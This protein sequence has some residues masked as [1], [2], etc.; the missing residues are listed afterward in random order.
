MEGLIM[1][2]VFQSQER[3][4]TVDQSE[5]NIAVW[6]KN[7]EPTLLDIASL[8]WNDICSF[9]YTQL[10]PMLRQSPIISIVVGDSEHSKV[11]IQRLFSII[12][13]L[14]CSNRVY[15]YADHDLKDFLITQQNQYKIP[16]LVRLGDT[17]PADWIV[18]NKGQ[19][20]FLIFGQTDKKRSFGMF[21]EQDIAVSLF[22][23]FYILFWFHST[24]EAFG[25]QTGVLN[26]GVPLAPPFQ[27]PTDQNIH[28]LR[29]GKL[30]MMGTFNT[31]QHA[32]IV[33]ASQLSA[34]LQGTFLVVPPSLHWGTPQQELVQ[35]DIPRQLSQANSTLL[36]FPHELPQINISTQRLLLDL[37]GKKISLRLE[38][39]RSKAIQYRHAL[40]GVCLNPEWK[41]YPQR[42][43]NQ[44][45]G[46]V[47]ISGSKQAHKVKQKE[48]IVLRPVEVPISLPYRSPERNLP[49][50]SNLTIRTIYKWKEEPKLLPKDAIKDPLYK[51]WNKID[52]WARSNLNHI[53][54]ILQKLQNTNPLCQKT[55]NHLLDYKEQRSELADIDPSQNVNNVLEQLEQIVQLNAAVETL[56]QTIYKLQVQQEKQEIQADQNRTWEERIEIK[57]WENETLK[58]DLISKLSQYR[59]YEKNISEKTEALNQQNVPAN[60]RKIIKKEIKNIQNA[61]KKLKQEFDK[62]LAAKTSEIRS[63]TTN[64]SEIV[65]PDVP[66]ERLPNA[67][68]LYTAQGTRYLAIHRW[69]KVAYAQQEVGTYQAVL[70]AS[71]IS[72]PERVQEVVW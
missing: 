56:A 50:P 28:D 55:N 38:W 68:E 3:E 40:M 18:F 42:T 71:K 53:G 7:N 41:F 63:Y 2:G 54:A 34:D 57:T 23:S 37:Q 64:L 60:K 45:N 26:F 69:E 1:Q 32:E 31:L 52:E 35:M 29:S 51:K 9:D 66:S 22:Q 27:P 59:A 21:T 8:G 61:C 58:Q 30:Q 47:L 12:S 11:F 49:P 72:T 25:N 10:E 24:K 13:N 36:W 39:D 65:S 48:E 20:A 14:Q 33:V 5:K 62:H 6:E 46:D 44:I 67:G 70:V 43:L 15:I 17:P 4:Q 16:V 19:E